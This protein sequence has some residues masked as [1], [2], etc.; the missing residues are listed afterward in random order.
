MEI[1]LPQPKAR[2]SYYR[3]TAVL[4][5]RLKNNAEHAPLQKWKQKALQESLQPFSSPDSSPLFAEFPASPGEQDVTVADVV[6]LTD[7]LGLD[8]TLR[9]N[10]PAGEWQ[11]L[12]FGYTIGE[13]FFCF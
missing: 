11:V 9:W 12:R 3:D 1:K 2:D 7:K 4:A 10:A 8:G 6:N 5:Y 13:P